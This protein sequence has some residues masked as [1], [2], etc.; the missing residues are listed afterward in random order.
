[1]KR[2]KGISPEFMPMRMEPK[3]TWVDWVL[4]VFMWLSI[5]SIPATVLYFGVTKGNL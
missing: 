5:A 4:I 1:M 3:K 2:T